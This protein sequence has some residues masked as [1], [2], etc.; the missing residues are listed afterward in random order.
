[1]SILNKIHNWIISKIV[2]KKCVVINARVRVHEFN[3]CPL[4]LGD[5]LYSD[6]LDINTNGKTVSITNTNEED[7][8]EPFVGGFIADGSTDPVEIT[9]C[10]TC[11]IIEDEECKGKG[12]NNANR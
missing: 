3:G 6:G 10:Y 11:E 2:G 9:D 12:Y 5:V 7:E 4:M 8:S 1:M